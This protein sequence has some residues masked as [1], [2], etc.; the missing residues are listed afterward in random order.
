MRWVLGIS[1]TALR[2]VKELQRQAAAV[3]ELVAS[4]NQYLI[5]RLGRSRIPPLYKSGVLYRTDPSEWD[6]QFQYYPDAEAILR[7]GWTDCKGA[8]AYRLADLRVEY[9]TLNFGVHTYPRRRGKDVCI[10]LQVQL[11]DGQIED[12]SRLLHQ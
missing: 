11:P 7:R 4:Q 3:A 10:H 6:P 9:P 8:V 1:S 2:D 12:P 5:R